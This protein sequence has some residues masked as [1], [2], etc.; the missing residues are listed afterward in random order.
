MKTILEQLEP[1]NMTLEKQVEL[2]G[3]FL[4]MNFEN[5]IGNNKAAGEGAIEMAVRLLT[6]LKETEQLEDIYCELRGLLKE[7][8][9]FPDMWDTDEE[10]RAWLKERGQ[11]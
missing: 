10:L 4:I 7:H 8:A 11:L 1:S 6:K 9:Q 5:D 2:L 3:E